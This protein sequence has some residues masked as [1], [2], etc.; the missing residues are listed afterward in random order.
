MDKKQQDFLISY[1]NKKRIADDLAR[2]ELDLTL[3]KLQT[4]RDRTQQNN[5]QAEGSGKDD[6][7][8]VTTNEA[9]TTIQC[10]S[11]IVVEETNKLEWRAAKDEEDRLKK[12]QAAK[13]KDELMAGKKAP[14]KTPKKKKQQ[15][16]AVQE[17]NKGPA[18]PYDNL[19]T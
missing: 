19:I 2:A 13:K 3:D 4:M 8:N 18:S 17:D 16:K 15:A 5:K 11:N 6:G 10:K 7:T 12:E 1:N 14:K 9:T